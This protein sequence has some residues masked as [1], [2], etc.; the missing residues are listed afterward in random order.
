MIRSFRR[1]LVL[2]IVAALLAGGGLVWWSREQRAAP[3]DRPVYVA[4]GASDAIGIGADRPLTQGWVALVHDG[5]PPGTILVN[6]GIS[7][8]TLHDVL[9]DE[10]PVAVDARP[11]WVTLWPG[12]NDLRVGVS[13]ASFS[14]DLDTLL[15]QLAAIPGARVVVLNIPDLRLVPA[16]ADRDPA[17]LDA[18]VR[19]WN[20]TIAAAAARHGATLV[21]LYADAQE[22]AKH[23]EFVSAD[24]F[25]PSSLGYRRI[26]ELV[27]PAINSHAA[28]ATP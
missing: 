21:D 11:R 8:A 24:G 27:L 9:N 20:A 25:H 14:Q 10:A 23:P 22:E 18:T 16:F 26:A 6:L 13:L 15:G 7:G 1:F 3:A 17:R 19:Q 4:L 5:L 28:I 2:P 12:V